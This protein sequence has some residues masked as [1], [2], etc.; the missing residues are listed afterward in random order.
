MFRTMTDD[1]I[2]HF[3]LRPP[4][5]WQRGHSYDIM[6]VDTLTPTPRFMA[7]FKQNIR[8]RLRPA[9]E[10]ANR[11]DNLW[12]RWSGE[13]GR[14][15]GKHI[16]TSVPSN[17]LKK[18]ALAKRRIRNA[19][20]PDDVDVYVTMTESDTR[21][22]CHLRSRRGTTSAE[23]YHKH[24]NACIGHHGHSYETG[25]CAM[26]LGNNEWNCRRRDQL[27][28][29]NPRRRLALGHDLWWETGKTVLLAKE[30]SARLLASQTSLHNDQNVN[31]VK[32]G[33]LSFYVPP[34]VTAETLGLNW[35]TGRTVPG[36]AQRMVT[37][38][39][40]DSS[41][42]QPKKQR[43]RPPGSKNSTTCARS[44]AL[45]ANAAAKAGQRAPTSWHT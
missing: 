2:L 29:G 20:D 30:A 9:A 37:L 26:A 40:L 23:E 38:K 41:N 27:P 6:L 44:L 24:G 32:D 19:F 18:F 7:T 43:G 3:L 1:E 31:R 34:V 11:L 28:P 42:T 22:L 17:V 10:I 12:N 21:G 15:N 16:F 35:Q 45:A 36:Q 25:V 13:R 8:K 39:N 33:I 4:A 14:V 5:P